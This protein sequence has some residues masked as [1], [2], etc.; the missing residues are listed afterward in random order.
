M[1]IKTGGGIRPLH[2]T[3]FNGTRVGVHGAEET[4]QAIGDTCPPAAAVSAARAAFTVKLLRRKRRA[5]RGQNGVRVRN[6][7][8]S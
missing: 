4:R 3:I 5:E 7:S 8:V 1:F 2:R 6:A